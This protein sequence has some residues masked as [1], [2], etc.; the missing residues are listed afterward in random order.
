MN[1]NTCIDF[2]QQ[3]ELKQK[4]NHDKSQ[5]NEQ[6]FADNYML[7]KVLKNVCIMDVK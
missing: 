5:P 6:I 7:K 3:Q 2:I 1:L 4:Y